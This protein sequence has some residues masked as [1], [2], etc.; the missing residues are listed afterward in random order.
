MRRRGKFL[1]DNTVKKRKM[2][3]FVPKLQ[4][5]MR[6][7]W[8]WVTHYPLSSFLIVVIWFL[9]FWLTPPPTPL[10]DVAFIDKW[11]HLTMYLGT[12]SVIWWEYLRRHEKV[13]WLKTLTWAWAGPI[14]MSGLIELL[15]A[16]CTGGRRSGE[17]LDFAANATGATL[18][19]VIGI[20]AARY[21][22]KG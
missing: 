18:A 5:H 15:Q 10:D 14:M 9:C 17:W 13:N 20:L 8:H 4:E 3:N 16:Y 19:L 21:L 2:S 6:Y 1:P 22:G 7:P 12:C 11:T